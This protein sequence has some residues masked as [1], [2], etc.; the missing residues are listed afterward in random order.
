MLNAWPCKLTLSTLQQNLCLELAEEHHI[1]HAALPISQYVEMAARRVLTVNQCFDIMTKWYVYDEVSG[2]T[3]SRLPYPASR[4][5]YRDWEKAFFEVI[6]KR[7]Y[8]QPKH[9]E[10]KKRKQH[11]NYGTP[12][13][14]AENAGLDGQQASSLEAQGD[15]Q[16]VS[17]EVP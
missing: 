12:S 9:G 16:T 5:E 13:N 14:E 4:L 17:A 15:I 1:Q 3:I 7:K 6:P 11:W 8:E 2:F 10:P